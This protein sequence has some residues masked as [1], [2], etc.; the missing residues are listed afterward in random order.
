MFDQ[1]VG[2][3]MRHV[4]AVR[5]QQFIK[6]VL[7]HVWRAARAQLSGL[8]WSQPG[9]MPTYLS[10]HHSLLF[11]GVQSF[12]LAYRESVLL[13]MSSSHQ[14][15]TGLTKRG[16]AASYRPWCGQTVWCV[17]Q[18][19]IQVRLIMLLYSC[20]LPPS[21]S[22][23]QYRIYFCVCRQRRNEIQRPLRSVL[24]HVALYL[25]DSTVAAQ[26][27]HAAPADRTNSLA[28]SINAMRD[29][30]GSLSVSGAS[31]ATAYYMPR[32]SYRCWYLCTLYR[33]AGKRRTPSTW[34]AI[35]ATTA[36]KEMSA[37]CGYEPLL[38]SNCIRTRLWTCYGRQVNRRLHRDGVIARWLTEAMMYDA[39]DWS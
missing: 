5:L 12:L 21:S 4:S 24:Q 13:D 2:E 29:C 8:N 38:S 17:K 19:Q 33:H 32:L 23:S 14:L 15:Q 9:A 28:V 22:L 25:A 30:S 34:N 37:Q 11:V 27:C 36:V 10:I 18:T 26:C 6:S 16:L 3:L 7:I 1:H 39:R 35:Y 20:G 31:E